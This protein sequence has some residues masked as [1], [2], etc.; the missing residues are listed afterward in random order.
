VQLALEQR[1]CEER[2]A[3]QVFDQVTVSRVWHLQ[4]VYWPPDVL[5]RPMALEA[6]A[7]KTRHVLVRRQGS[8][9]AELERSRCARPRRVFS[10]VF[11]C[12]Y[13]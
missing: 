1:Q 13:S 3:M 2:A 11:H 7:W 8:L 5:Q 10:S 9:C 4:V 6:A 12:C